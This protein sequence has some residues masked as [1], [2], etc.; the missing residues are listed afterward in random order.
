MKSAKVYQQW[1]EKYINFVN[2]NNQQISCNSVLNFFSHIAAEYCASSLW[3]CYSCIGKYL[4]VNHNVNI[5]ESELIELPLM[6]FQTIRT[7]RM[8]PHQ[9]KT[10]IS[11]IAQ[12]L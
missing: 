8:A 10:C 9:L 6:L 5:K 3:Q 1:Y 7:I 11:L 2:V 12:G 4:L